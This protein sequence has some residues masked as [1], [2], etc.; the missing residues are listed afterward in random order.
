MLKD[1]PLL[2]TAIIFGGIGLLL[3]IVTGILFLN[4]NNDAFDTIGSVF[5]MESGKVTAATI[6]QF[7]LVFEVVAFVIGYRSLMEEAEE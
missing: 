5:G 2:I 7:S 1:K 4:G 6:S 3:M